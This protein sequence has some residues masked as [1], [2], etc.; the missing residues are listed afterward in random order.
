MRR[1]GLFLVELLPVYGAV[2]LN[3]EM[4]TF[5]AALKSFTIAPRTE[6]TLFTFTAPASSDGSPH[7]ITEQWFSFFGGKKRYNPNIDCRIR[8]YL[9][10]SKTPN[11]DFQLYFAHAIGLQSCTNS[12]NLETADSCIDPRVPW[13]SSEVQHMAHGGALKNRYRIPFTSGIKITAT[14]PDSATAGGVLYYYV[15]GMTALPVIVGDVQLPNSARLTL[16]KNWGVTVPPMG[17]LS[18]VPQ[19]N[20]SGLLYATM[21]SA[22][23][24]FIGF[25]EGC[26][27]AYI[28]ERY[29]SIP[30]F[31]SSGTEDYFESANFF[32]AGHPP[33]P[34]FPGEAANEVFNRSDETACPESGV[35]YVSGFNSLTKGFHYSMAAYKFHLSDPIVWWR[36][37][38]LTASNYDG[39]G[40][41]PANGDNNPVGCVVPTHAIPGKSSNVTMHTYAWTYEW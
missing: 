9:E 32:N 18:L 2:L 17:A 10:G 36:N 1:A 39:S 25:M 20:G 22:Q 14:L 29:S 30:L 38:M 7:T 5:G 31:M 15:R 40:E 11:L 27:R 6:Q 26:V 19:R 23:S 35:S 8:V 41:D 13:S 24:T 37:F 34:W 16:H 12:S 28:D 3:K 21:W 4:Q 33:P